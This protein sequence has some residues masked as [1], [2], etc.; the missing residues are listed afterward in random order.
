LTAHFLNVGHGDCTIVD[1]PSGRLMMVDVNNSRSLPDTD[2]DALAQNKGLTLGEF[3][4]TFSK[5]FSWEDYYRGLLVDPSEYFQGHFSGRD[6]FRYIQ[7]H[8][9]MDHMSGLARLFWF[10]QVGLLNFWDT[11]HTKDF[12]EEE[13]DKSRFEWADW[14]AYKLMRQ[15]VGPN[16]EFRV[17][18]VTAGD[19]RSYWTEDGITILSPT[20]DLIDYANATQNWN[21][22]SYVLRIE[23]GGRSLILPGDAEKPAWDSIEANFSAD[24]LSCDVLKAAHHGRESGFSESAATTMNPSY[25][26]CSVGKKPETDASDEYTNLG[27]TVLST[28]YNGTITV[29]MWEDGEV[30]IN[31]HKGDRIGSLPILR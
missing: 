8:P 28:R 26:I 1:F 3:R 13:F 19:S 21:N 29:Q 7:T 4:S 25:V 18:R 5:T 2:K 31:N 14:M 10:D 16:G 15:G 27:A 22:L 20:D 17:F 9:D 30:W 24:K 12:T 6:I 11:S 23:F